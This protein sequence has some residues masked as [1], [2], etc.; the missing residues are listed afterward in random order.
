MDKKNKIKELL[1]R[2][3]SL[4]GLPTQE[5]GDFADQ[6]VSSKMKGLTEEIRNDATVAKMNEIS[7]KLDRFKT[8]FN[9]APLSDSIDEIN[10][11]ILT[12]EK[13]L[14]GLIDQKGIELI[15][16]Q[17]ASNSANEEITEQLSSELQELRIALASLVD[18]KNSIEELRLEIKALSE[19]FTGSQTSF[20]SSLDETKGL[21]PNIAPL[22]DSLT[23][24]S[25]HIESV[26]LDLLQRISSIGGGQA[27]RN[28]VFSGSV[29]T[30][31]TDV[32]FKGLS[33]TNND[34]TKQAD[35]TITG[36]TAI[37]DIVSGGSDTAVLFIHPSSVLSQDVNNFSFQDNATT[38]S[39]LATNTNVALNINNAGD[40]T[41]TDAVN[42]YAQYDAYL[43]NSLITNSL[44]GLN[45][46]GAFPGYTTSSSRGTGASPSQLQAN[47]MV[48]GYFG[49]GSQGASSPTYQNLGGMAI[50]TTGASANNLGGQLNFYTKADGGS[51]VNN[52][53]ML[54]NGGLA[55]HSVAAAN[56]ITFYNTSDEV[57]NT[58]R[59]R[60]FWSSNQLF[61]STENTG[62]GSARNIIIG[63]TTRGF[64]VDTTVDGYGL[65]INSGSMGLT[66]V[67]T[68]AIGTFSAST[69]IVQKAFQILPTITQA[70]TAGFTALLINPTLSAQGS[71][72][73][74]LQDWQAG[75]SSL[76]SV[77]S[78]GQLI[79]HSTASAQGIVLYNTSDEV[80]NTEKL[81]LTWNGNIAVIATNNSGTGSPRDLKLSNPNGASMV[82]GNGSI[83]IQFA[84]G[85]GQAGYVGISYAPTNTAS[86]G[87]QTVL[88][89]NPT[90][91]QTGTASYTGILLNSI[92]SGSTANGTKKLIDLQANSSSKYTIDN[93]GLA[94]TV[95]GVTTAGWG[96]PTI[97]GS[98]RTVG[99]TAAVASVAT[100]T[101]GAADGTFLISANVLVTTAT[102]HAFTVT[103]TYTDEGNTSRT[104]TLQ[105]SNLAGTFLT[106]IA[107]T[108]GTVP[109]EGVPV[110]IRCKA[111]TSITIG[112]AA[113]GVYTSVVYNI[114]GSIIQLS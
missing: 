59:G 71:G 3:N 34:T 64:T 72:L 95:K 1:D 76:L 33:F 112:S 69:A 53:S 11:T 2:L 79:Q 108:A 98:G 58:E 100:Y 80:T 106:S 101:V 49:F 82:L 52:I 46:D 17:Q 44:T 47:D 9:L 68:S 21:I 61:L 29:L 62:T 40:T 24:L 22:S 28:I 113:G 35:V 60:L 110:Q 114:E 70:S 43:P 94:T 20:Q 90:F 45:T 73:Q 67:G 19:T 77:N 81:S 83:G 4:D 65:Q 105:F 30:R 50:L 18:P 89:L 86:T 92:D 66:Q 23:T 75:S 55:M 74:L 27:N 16:A 111:A 51:L 96:I 93:T 88:S 10:K 48:G 99:A 84:R 15:N 6:I 42:I 25:Q 102:T 8:D 85:S 38:P 41:G 107:N 97:Y 91:N 13:E 56:G 87:L 32:N 37:G 36:N 57:T 26:R 7:T 5:V 12:K 109:Y 14:R 31:Y 39:T 104:L 78:V 54:N 103:C 63:T